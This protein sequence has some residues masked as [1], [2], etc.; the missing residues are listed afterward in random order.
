MTEPHARPPI[1][2]P[3][4]VLLGA[5][6]LNAFATVGTVT[7]V[8]KQVFDM[9]GRELDLGLIGLAEFLPMA[10]L[11]PVT[12][13]LAD[14]FDRRLMFAIGLTGDVV[15]SIAMFSYVNTDPTSVGPIFGLMVLFALTRSVGTPAARAI[16][17]D[18]A[19][20]DVLERVI[21]LRSVAFQA[22]IIS[23]PLVLAWVF[24]LD[25]AAPYLVAAAAYGLAVVIVASMPKLPTRKL[26]T[27]GGMQAIR[28]AR[29]GLRF[30]RRQPVVFG[31]ISLDLFAVLFGGIIALLPAIAEKRL[32]VGAV[33][34][35]GLRAAVGAGSAVV[36]LGLA[37]RPVRRHVGKI[38]LGVIAVFGVMHVAVA[39][40]TNYIVAVVALVIAA[41]S[42]QISVYI[43]S[44]LVPLATPEEMRGRVLAVE[45][46]FIGASNELGAV[47]SGLTAAAFGLVGAMVFGSVGTLVVVAVWWRYFP[48]LRDVDR[49]SDVRAP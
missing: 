33:G 12:G 15:V 35:G 38:L 29:E 46:V 37:V 14:R 42:D 21:P 5:Y 20:P 36:A 22:G 28:D 27:R 23:G 16:T 4:R 19:P 6:F 49:F 24:V 1:P 13:S 41:G 17:I 39:L 18:M 31:A 40:T 43:R 45:N 30:I 10:L 34:L 11:A 44:T 9:T 7:I 3:L 48:A 26:S 25:I 8:G 47:E 2:V 32:G